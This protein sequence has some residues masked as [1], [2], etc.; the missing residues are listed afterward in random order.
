VVRQLQDGAGLDVDDSALRDLDR[1]GGSPRYI[2][3][4][5]STTDEG[6]SWIVSRWRRPFAP[7][8]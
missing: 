5:P 1:S 2:V 7:G 6:S 3:S 8:G 4:V